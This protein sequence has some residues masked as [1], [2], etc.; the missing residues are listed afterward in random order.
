MIKDTSKDYDA[1]LDYVAEENLNKPSLQNFINENN[2]DEEYR[3]EV[4]AKNIDK[5][6]PEEWQHLYVNFKT[7][8]EYEQFM[9][10]IGY[11]PIPKLK[12]LV[13]EKQDKQ[14]G[15]FQFME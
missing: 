14:S 13:F 4:K 3:P 11:R 12:E 2:V 6:F 10:I 8:E 15:L 7:I 5:D 9:N 1:M